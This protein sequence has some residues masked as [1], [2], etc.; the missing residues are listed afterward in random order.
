M[1]AFD[2]GGDGLVDVTELLQTLKGGLNVRRK[3][4]VEK[5]WRKFDKTGNGVVDLADLRGVFD[6][7]RHPK[8][9]SGEMSVDDVLEQ[10][11]LQFEG[12]NGD[13]TLTREE[14]FEYYG[15]ISA[16]YDND[17]TFE[18]VLTRAWNLDGHTPNKNGGGHVSIAHEIFAS[19]TANAATVGVDLPTVIDTIRQ[20][21]LQQGVRLGEF[22]KDYDKLN[23]GVVTPT[24]FRVALEQLALR[25][26]LSSRHYDVIF[27][28]YPSDKVPGMINYRA[29]LHDV[30]PVVNATMSPTASFMPGSRFAKS[31]ST[32]DPEEWRTLEEAM[33]KF[34]AETFARRLVLRT[35]FKDFEKHNRG[36]IT[37]PQFQRA[38]PFPSMVTPDEMRVLMKRYKDPLSSD[39]NYLAW[40]HD[41]ESAADEK[42]AG[43]RP[44][45]S[46]R[47][48][49]RTVGIEQPQIRTTPSGDAIVEE[50]KRLTYAHRISFK[51]IF[52]GYDK[53][54][55][56]VVTPEQFKRALGSIRIPQFSFSPPA[57][58]ILAERYN[59][60]PALVNYILFCDE[61]D[62]V[63]TIKGLEKSP[64]RVPPAAPV[65]RVGGRGAGPNPGYEN[66][67]QLDDLLKRLWTKIRT[68]R[69]L[70]KPHLQ[71]Y[72]RTCKGVN[73]T[74]YVT[75]SRFERA[76]S[77]VGLRLTSDEYKL[78]VEAYS[79]EQEP[80]R[81]D[82]HRFL[83]DLEEDQV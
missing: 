46:D 73:Q 26:A 25:A 53:L 32:L 77:Q 9:Q 7:S 49:R 10:Y 21:A 62:S 80:G 11:L 58:E 72:D 34:V 76:L 70:L 65:P 12:Q 75:S 30:D 28:A 59:V 24:Q 83:K 51:D 43:P 81:V 15:G 1:Q 36:K 39:I 37:P 16:E 47:K 74:R 68:E 56:D 2:K 29:F 23:R 4:V 35:F 41:V 19:D 71:D 66:D 17:E 79:A 48:M 67:A 14:F 6:A 40:C 54:R 45:S 5:A 50:L 31:T 42:N 55:K 8:V 60:G 18:L 63:F 82:Y 78:L 69:I 64:T 38:F 44:V 3:A 61:M 52:I 20:L 27:K 33:K 57:L 13:G 22:F